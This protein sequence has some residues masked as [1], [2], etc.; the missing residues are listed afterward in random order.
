LPLSALAIAVDK[1]RHRLR[2]QRPQPLLP[3][4]T[5]IVAPTIDRRHTQSMMTTAIAKLH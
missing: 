3:T 1:D 4:T 2:R 5:A